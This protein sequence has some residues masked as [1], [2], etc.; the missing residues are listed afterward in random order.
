[1]IIVHLVLPDPNDVSPIQTWL[2]EHSAIVIKQFVVSN[3][4][5]YIIYEDQ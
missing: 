2:D 3:Y 5:V 4:D 1:M